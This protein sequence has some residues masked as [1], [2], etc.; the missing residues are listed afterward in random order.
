[1]KDLFKRFGIK[2]TIT[3]AQE[4]FKTRIANLLTTT[5]FAKIFDKEEVGFDI[6]WTVAMKFGF[7]YKRWSSPR[8]VYFLIFPPY[9]SFK[10]YLARLQ[11]IINLLWKKEK[12]KELLTKL[13]SLIQL[14]IEDLPTDLGIK[15]TFFNKK[16]P[17]I[18]PAGVKI[19]DEKVENVLGMLEKENLPEVLEQFEEGLKEFLNAKTKQQLKDVVED[20]LGTCDVLMHHLFQDKNIGFKHL[21][22]DDRWKKLGLNDYQKQ[23]LWNLKE[24]MDKIKHGAIENYSKDLE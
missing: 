1:M 20:M 22:K 14:F 21:F 17:Q 7:D 16:P 23:I 10:E 9:L 24:W 4:K 5:E 6:V 18:Y 19:L 8:E 3:D 2:T 15:I 11:Y 12:I 13:V